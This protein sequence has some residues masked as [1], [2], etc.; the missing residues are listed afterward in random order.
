MFQLAALLEDCIREAQERIPRLP[1]KQGGMAGSLMPH[2]ALL[3]PTSAGPDPGGAGVSPVPGRHPSEA[4]V[5][6][7]K[8]PSM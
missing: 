7:S 1:P 4:T 5:P 8:D 3:P 6:D 2:S